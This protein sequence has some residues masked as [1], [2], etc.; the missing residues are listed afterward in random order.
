MIYTL[1]LNPA[2]DYVMHTAELDIG[3]IQRSQGEKIYFG[4]KGINVSLILKELGVSSV[5]TGFVAGFTG[6]TIEKGIASEKIKTDFVHL[7]NGFTRINVKIR[8]EVETDIN[9]NGPNI[10]AEDIDCLIKKLDKLNNGDI[11]VLA[12]SVPKCV[13]QN[14]YEVIMERLSGKG[15]EFIVDA[16]KELL[17]NTLKYKPFL[18]KPNNEELGEIFGIKIT[19]H[20]DALKFAQ[21][22]KEMGAQN[23]L[24][25]FGSK[26]AFLLDK[27]NE[28]HYADSLCSKA[29]NTVGA[30][31]SMVA[32]FIA[33]YLEKKNFD[34]ALKLGSAAG[35]AT[36]SSE[37]LASREDII[38]LFK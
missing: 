12:G 21:K 18:I 11:L 34:Y 24:V 32:G 28:V 15:V 13:P 17:L 8:S 9:G 23:V 26:G 37:G 20:K 30:G 35:G 27:N 16:E 5:A 31:D 1:T 22:L 14:I 10:L 2:I 4:G 38:K 33:G 19:E 7:S 3:S 6:E 25:S 29:V 36:A